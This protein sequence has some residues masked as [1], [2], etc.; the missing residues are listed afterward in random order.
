MVLVIEPVCK[1]WVHEVV[2]SGMIEL[3]YNVFGDDITVTADVDHIRCIN[4]LYKNNSIKYYSIDDDRFFTD[5]DNWKSVKNYYSYINKLI[6]EI[7]PNTVFILTAYRPCLFAA[8]LL[9]LRFKSIHF[10]ITLH[11]MIE[12]DAKKQL[13]Y[14]RIMHFGNSIRNLNYITYSPYCTSSHWGLSENKIVFIHH[15][16]ISSVSSNRIHNDKVNVC[17]IG[18]CANSRARSIIRAVNKQKPKGEYEF[19][20]MS[21]NAK[22]FI[23]LRNTI[24]LEEV[25][26]RQEVE[27]VLRGVDYLLLPYKHEYDISAS[28]VLWEGAMYDIPCLMLDS[29]YFKYYNKYHTGYIAS[30]VSEMASTITN[31]INTNQGKEIKE[32]KWYEGIEALK[33]HN[34]ENLRNRNY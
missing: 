24:I 19:I 17:I 27:S 32:E 1:G 5:I 2:N 20:L 25:F 21:K 6:K 31:I 4:N 12:N 18:Q 22:E 28:G 15:P 34:I 14:K 30:S 13:D 11:R 16:Y 3:V 29:R 7:K 9:S 10:Y 26:E 23:G 33:T 8:E